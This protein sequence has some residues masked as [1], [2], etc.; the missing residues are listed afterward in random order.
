MTMPMSLVLVRHAESEHN[1]VQQASKH[2]RTAPAN[3]SEVWARHGSQQRLSAE[4][5]RQAQVAGDWLRANNMNPSAFDLRLVSPFLRTLETASILAPDALWLPS[6]RVVER[7]W[8]IFGTLPDEERAKR[9]ADTE[10]MK[11]ASSFFTR[12]DGGESIFDTTFRVEAL[13][14]S[15]D[16]EQGDR[17]VIVVTHG[18][19]MWA[20][21]AVVE[22]L[23]PDE[24]QALDAD[25]SLRIPN[26]CVLELDRRCPFGT[27]EVAR[28]L[29]SCWRRMTDPVHPERS[30]YGGRWVRLPGKRPLGSAAISALL[31]GAPPLL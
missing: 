22:L 29:S 10:A 20:T 18:E 11:E 28:S 14:G 16:R 9:F 23:M 30:P 27:G 4:G 24:W 7:D 26:C 25:R 2:G 21:R 12:F 6:R 13:L 17:R 19:F 5:R 8:G 1:V 31:A 3:A 15:L